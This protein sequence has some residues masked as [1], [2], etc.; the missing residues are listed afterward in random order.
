MA[1][2]FD[3]LTKTL[4]NEKLRRRQAIRRISGIVAGA[5]LASWLP[6]RAFAASA[7][8]HRC[9]PY[10]TCSSTFS[11]CG[12]NKYNNCYCFQK[13]GSTRSTKGVCAC[14]TYCATFAPCTNQTQCQRGYACITNTGCG[15]TSGT[16]IQ[17][18][19]RTCQLDSTRSGRTAA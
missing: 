15:C 7:Q 19:T 13:M 12:I 14:N 11:N 4:A 9:S 18:C 16:C 1:N 5:A 2:W 17:K 10:G 8:K 6:G 3:D